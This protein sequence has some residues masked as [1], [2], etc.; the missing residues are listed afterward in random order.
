MSWFQVSIKPVDARK[1]A[2]PAE[3]LECFRNENS[4][5]RKLA[6]LVTGDLALAD[7]SVAKARES[8]LKGNAPFRDWLLEWAKSLTVNSAIASTAEGIRAC[9]AI[10]RV[11]HCT[12]I[13]LLWLGDDDRTAS[14]NQVLQADP[15]RLI[16]ELDPLCR[17]ILVLRVAIRSSIQDCVLRLNVS[18]TAVLAG[19]C[20]AITWL[21]DLQLPRGDSSRH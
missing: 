14:L 7:Q 1:H 5:L 3:I 4:L 16:A 6:F 8:T 12:H 17:A 15:Q 19:H 18:R 20:Q 2:S 11:R 21:Y 13:E 10:Y 9:D